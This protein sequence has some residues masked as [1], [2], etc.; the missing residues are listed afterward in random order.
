MKLMSLE[1]RAV[2]AKRGISL[3]WV[4]VVPTLMGMWLVFPPPPDP[5]LGKALVVCGVTAMAIGLLASFF[6]VLWPEEGFK[7]RRGGQP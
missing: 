5:T 3:M 4:G 6:L 7:P 1:R 2:W